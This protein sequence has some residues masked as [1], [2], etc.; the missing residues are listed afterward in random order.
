MDEGKYDVG[1]NL[2]P[3]DAPPG[4]S[5]PAQIPT[6]PSKQ[7][8]SFVKGG[9]RDGKLRTSGHSGAHRIGKRK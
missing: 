7:G 9:A 1:P 4:P 5:G 8:T 2:P 6:Q 3:K